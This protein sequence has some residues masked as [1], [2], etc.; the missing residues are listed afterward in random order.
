MLKRL[1]FIITGFIIFLSGHSQS[2]GVVAASG[3]NTSGG[4]GSLSWVIGRPVVATMKSEERNIVLTQGIQGNLPASAV[5]LL[6]ETEMETE[7]DLKLFPNPAEDYINVRFDTP[8]RN[9]M[10]I[11]LVDS[12]G[13][14]IK[15]ETIEPSA[16][17]KQLDIQNIPAGIYFLRLTAGSQSKIFKV[18]K[19]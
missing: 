11:V 13:N 2:V 17:L 14:I 1:I 8:A 16:V 9:E 7:M 12:K 6:S 15:D 19:L 3:S 10:R 5:V 4:S 18:V